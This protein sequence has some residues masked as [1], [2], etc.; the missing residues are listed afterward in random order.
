MPVPTQK[1]AD[2]IYTTTTKWGG[3]RQTC[4]SPE[5]HEAQ[6]QRL[7]M[8]SQGC[9]TH[10]V[11]SAV[12]CTLLH[13][14]LR[15]TFGRRPYPKQL[16]STEQMRVKGLA[17]GPSNNSLVC[18]LWLTARQ[19]MPSLSTREHGQFCSFDSDTDVRGIVSF[20]SSTAWWRVNTTKRLWTCLLLDY[21]KRLVNKALW[22]KCYY[23]MNV[24]TL[25][26]TF[27][28]LGFK[29]LPFKTCFASAFLSELLLK[30]Y[31]QLL[32]KVIR[33]IKKIRIFFFNKNCYGPLEPETVDCRAWTNAY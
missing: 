30:T 24:L 13:L 33:W 28:H 20:L 23:C 18:F 1:H 2:F 8:Q 11:E 7:L 3:W 15:Q 12:C 5:T 27:A 16:Y 17:Q 9:V 32:T 10:S 31:Q 14:H 26:Q 4:T 21:E 6:P 25:I 22:R 29:A 19:S